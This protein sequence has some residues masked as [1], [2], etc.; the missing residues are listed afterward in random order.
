M[1]SKSFRILMLCLVFSVC[2]TVCAAADFR[3]LPCDADGDMVL[4]ADEV[5]SAVCSYMLREDRPL[6]DVK[7]AAY[8]C[9]Y[10]GGEP[11]TLTD[12]TGREFT[13]YRPVSRVVTTNPDNSRIVIAMGELDKLV[14]TDECTV[15]SSVLPREKGTKL[16]PGAWEQLQIYGGGQLDELPVTNTRKEID[17]E[18]IAMLKPDLVLD[19]RWYDRSELIEERIDCP[20]CA[21]GADFVFAGNMEHIRLI[22]KIFDKEERGEELVN[23]LQSQID[24]VKERTDAVPEEDRPTVYFAPRGAKKGFYDEVEGRDFTRTEAF[25][26]PLNAAGGI[27]V[28]AGVQGDTV[29]VAPEQIVAWNPDVIFVAWS[30]NASPDE[31]TGVDFVMETPEMA[32]VTAVKKAQVYSCVYPYSRGTPF[33]RSMLNMLYM[34]KCMYPDKFADISMEEY[35]NEL[36]RQI[37]GVDGLVTDLM[38]SWVFLKNVDAG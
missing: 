28:A 30:W 32:D 33:D 2:L 16:C 7:D 34:A 20:C 11:K 9:K 14:A 15:D 3:H 31:E 38:D 4:T 17:Y 5:N 25:Y 10:W 37:L 35:G 1:K 19:T 6:K 29:N 18:T 8:V 36:Y 12:S 13:M 26:E 22:A 24:M 23:Y 21:A 27:N